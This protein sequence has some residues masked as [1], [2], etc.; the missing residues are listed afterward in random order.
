MAHD[1]EWKAVSDVSPPINTFN[2][3]WAYT[4]RGSVLLGRWSRDS[5]SSSPRWTGG[6][7]LELGEVITHWAEMDTPEIPELC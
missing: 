6:I 1:V 5:F 2:P 3:L 7:A 4:D